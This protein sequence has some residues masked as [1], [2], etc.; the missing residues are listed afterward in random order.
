MATGVSPLTHVRRAAPLPPYLLTAAEWLRGD[1]R[2]PGAVRARNGRLA[3]LLFILADLYGQLVLPSLAEPRAGL[4]WAELLGWV[5]AALMLVLPWRRLPAWVSALPSVGAVA[6]LSAGTGG[7]S[8]ALEHF[9]AV[10]GL[11]FAYTGLTMRPGRTSAVAALAVAGVAGA[12]VLGRQDGGLVQVVATIVITATVGE[13]TALA[14]GAHR[15]AQVELNLL[16]ASLG[17]L[18]AASTES[19]AAQLTAALAQQLLVADGVMVILAEEPGSQ[20]LVGRGGVG[21]G[22]DT[23]SVRIDSAVEQSGVGTAVRSGAP[24]FVADAPTS[25]LFARRFIDSHRVA[26]ILY[27]P[28]PGEGGTLGVIAV[29]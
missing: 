1:G 16:N 6:L 20:V 24:L 19:E 2:D 10:Y 28:V 26:S 12:A 7:M 25:P 29:W 9:G 11:L 3:G 8:G 5:G 27:I 13:L 15:H 14:F 23:T 22:G 17:R 4:R 18:V 21:L